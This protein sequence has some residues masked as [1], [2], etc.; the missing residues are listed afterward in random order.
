[1][2][3]FRQSAK[4]LRASFDTLGFGKRLK[5]LEP[6]VATLIEVNSQSSSVVSAIAEASPQKLGNRAS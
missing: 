6:G 5:L 3:A 1:M 2:G 4:D